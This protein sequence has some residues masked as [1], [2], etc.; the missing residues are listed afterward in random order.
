MIEKGL[1]K[2]RAVLQTTKKT[3][4][5][6]YLLT[7]SVKDTAK[8]LNYS[9]SWVYRILYQVGLINVRLK[10]IRCSINNLSPTEINAIV[11]DY[12]SGLSTNNLLKVHNISSTTLYIILAKMNIPCRNKKRGFNWSKLSREN[13]VSLSA[14]VVY[15]YSEGKSMADIARTLKIPFSRV[16]YILQNLVINSVQHCEV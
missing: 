16:R 4:I 2:L 7:N 3:V 9:Y 8:E 10:K 1:G 13:Q 5:A 11:T 15:L 6:T 14:E 12:L